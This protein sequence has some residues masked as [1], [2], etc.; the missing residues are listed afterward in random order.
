MPAG[1]STRLMQDAKISLCPAT[2]EMPAHAGVHLRRS[3]FRSRFRPRHHA[4]RWH[5][6][7]SKPANINTFESSVR[8]VK[9][10][11]P[12]RYSAFSQTA[13]T[14]LPNRWNVSGSM[15]REQGTMQRS[16]SAS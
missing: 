5:L 16:Q 6:R 12:A 3:L 13:M 8:V 4:T 9:P 2:I 10:G 7:W 14:V 15:M 1:L 11:K